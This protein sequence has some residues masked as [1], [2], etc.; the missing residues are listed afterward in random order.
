VA[1]EDEHA[2]GHGHEYESVPEPANTRDELAPGE[3]AGKL[4]YLDAPSGL[5]GDMIIAALLDLGVPYGVVQ[6]ALAALPLAGFRIERATRVKHGIVA[7]SFD[8][9][10]DGGQPLRGYADIRAMIDDSDLSVGVKDRAQRTLLRL[11]SAESKVHRVPIANVHFHEVGAIDAIV[12][13]VGSAAAL[14]HIGADLVVSPLPMGRGFVR[15]AHGMLPLPAPATIECLVGLATIDGGLDFEFVTPTGAAIVGAHAV[16]TVSWPAMMPIRV[17]WGAGRAELPD[18]P[19]V[20]RAVLGHANRSDSG[21][22][23][24]HSVLEANIDDATGELAGTWI[25]T[26]LAAGALDAWV[27]PITMKKG[28]PAMTVSALAPI[29]K[30][31]ALA[32]AMLRETTTLGLRR[33]DV[34]RTER[35][36]RVEVVETPYGN[37]PVK[38][39]EGP[40][41]PPQLKPEFEACLFASRAHGVPVREVLRVALVHASRKLA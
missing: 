28:R 14:E 12:D 16:R 29:E 10:V 40:Y 22:R 34:V 41:G 20:L 23:F 6:G 1:P 3:G 33:H 18:R 38:V 27:T 36:R 17:G 19:N 4:L 37:I 24:T 39:S 8:V 31:D 35:P 5:A 7:A 9:H 32:D 2:P 11:G 13:V 21:G 25:E 26:L 30:A 15:A